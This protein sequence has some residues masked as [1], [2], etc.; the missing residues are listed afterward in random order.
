MDV[1]VI[2]YIEQVLWPSSMILT[3]TT[4]QNY[5]DSQMTNVDHLELK[6]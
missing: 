6:N 3:N 5:K 2:I 1:E 4:S